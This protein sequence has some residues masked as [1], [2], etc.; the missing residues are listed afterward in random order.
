MLQDMAKELER[1]GE[2]EKEIFE[3]AMCICE[4]GEKELQKVADD[5]SAAIETLTAKTESETAEKA[6]MAQEIKDHEATVAST[7]T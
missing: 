2:L 4:G 1:E 3:K 5:S 7:K 6:R